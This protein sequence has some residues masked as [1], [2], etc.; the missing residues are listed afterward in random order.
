MKSW[1]TTTAG[2]I[3]GLVLIAGEVCDAIGIPI[4]DVTNGVFELQNFVTGFAMMGI[5]LFAR[6]NNVSSE[7]AGA[8]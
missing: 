1:K 7:E 4:K 8:K 3:G 6:D 2:L 5:G